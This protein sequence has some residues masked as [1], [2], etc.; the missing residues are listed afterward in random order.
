MIKNKILVLFTFCLI[1]GGCSYLTGQKVS[2]EIPFK[3]D[4]GEEIKRERAKGLTYYLSKPTFSVIPEEIG[5][6]KKKKTLYS[7]KANFEADPSQRY[8][9]GMKQGWF[10]NDTFKLEQHTDGRLQHFG[11][12]THDETDQ[13][14]K[15]LGDIGKSVAKSITFGGISDFNLQKDEISPSDKLAK[16][17]DNRKILRHCFKKALGNSE[18]PL[19][20]SIVSMYQRLLKKEEETLYIQ[21]FMDD[22]GK[23]ELL[24]FQD[25]SNIRFDAFIYEL[26]RLT[27]S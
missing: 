8:E 1:A 17:Y 13:I 3:N 12:K 6:D 2:K 9:V 20:S 26:K 27:H 21:Q 11:V 24:R 23:L 18:P 25:T 19:A 5:E 7:I 14:I 4:D 10:T 22:S 15:G 16:L